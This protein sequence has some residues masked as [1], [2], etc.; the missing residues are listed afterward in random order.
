MTPAF[1]KIHPRPCLEKTAKMRRTAKAQVLRHLLGRLIGKIQVPL[2]LQ[3]QPPVDQPGRRGVIAKRE[4][5]GQ[6]LGRS[7]HRQGI[8]LYFVLT[9]KIDLQQQVE[10]PDDIHP[11]LRQPLIAFRLLLGDPRYI[12]DQ[13]FQQRPQHLTLHLVL[14]LHIL[15]TLRLDDRYAFHFFWRQRYEHRMP[16]AV[17]K[18]TDTADLG[19]MI[20]NTIKVAVELPGNQVLRLR[21][22]KMLIGDQGKD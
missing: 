7:V 21:E 11:V 5:I 22:L 17:K 10:L 12:D 6:G 1:R 16:D 4:K 2:R 3:D 14:H 13:P 19:V 18:K 15:H 9:T 8:K 20:G